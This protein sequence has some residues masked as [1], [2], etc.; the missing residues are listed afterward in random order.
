MKK[1][2]V[3]AGM[4]IFIKGIRNKSFPI[5]KIEDDFAYVVGDFCKDVPVLQFIKI[6]LIDLINVNEDSKFTLKDGVKYDEKILVSN[7]GL[8][9]YL[10]SFHSY[11]KLH[12]SCFTRLQ[13]DDLDVRNDISIGE[14]GFT[15]QESVYWKYYKRF[16]FID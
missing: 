1:E 16:N 7:N 4:E 14:D 5:D 12:G 2:D 13:S 3:K 10:R 8:S 15:D 9:W 6:S 11:G